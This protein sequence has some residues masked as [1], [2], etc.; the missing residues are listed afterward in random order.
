MIGDASAR[1][2]PGILIG[3]KS[4]PNSFLSKTSNYRPKD[5]GRLIGG[6]NNSKTIMIYSSQ[7]E[8]EKNTQVIPTPKQEQSATGI[9]QHQRVMNTPSFFV[10]DSSAALNQPGNIYTNPVPN[11]DKSNSEMWSSLLKNNT[12]NQNGVKNVFFT[13]SNLDEANKDKR[14]EGK[15]F[16]NESM[17][18]QSENNQNNAASQI[19]NFKNLTRESADPNNIVNNNHTTNRE[20]EQKVTRTGINVPESGQKFVEQNE[21]MN[22]YETP[23]KEAQKSKRDY[24][25]SNMENTEVKNG[26]VDKFPTEP[27]KKEIEDFDQDNMNVNDREVNNLKAVDPSFLA[28][29]KN[30]SFGADIDDIDQNKNEDMKLPDD[31]IEPDSYNSPN[32]NSPLEGSPIISKK[33]PLEDKITTNHEKTSDVA[34]KLSEIRSKMQKVN[35]QPIVN[36]AEQIPESRIEFNPNDRKLNEAVNTQPSENDKEIIKNT[37]EVVGQNTKTDYF[38]SSL[39]VEVKEEIKNIQERNND[40]GPSTPKNGQVTNNQ[41]DLNSSNKKLRSEK[42]TVTFTIQ[43]QSAQNQPNDK[44]L[45]QF[46]SKPAPANDTTIEGNKV[47]NFTS[48]GNNKDYFLKDINTKVKVEPENL[49]KPKGQNPYLIDTQPKKP[50]PPV[51]IKQQQNPTINEDINVNRYLIPL[52][53]SRIANDPL[54]RYLLDKSRHFA[55]HIENAKLYTSKTAKT[56]SRRMESIVLEYKEDR[57]MFE[58]AY[59]ASKVVQDFQ[60]IKQIFLSIEKDYEKTIQNKSEVL[61]TSSNFDANMNFRAGF[62]EEYNNR[63]LRWEQGFSKCQKIIDTRGKR[64]EQNS[65]ESFAGKSFH[66]VS[67]KNQILTI[68]NQKTFSIAPLTEK[69]VNWSAFKADNNTNE[70]IHKNLTM[71][72]RKESTPE[73]SK[74]GHSPKF[75]N[76]NGDLTR[77]RYHEISIQDTRLDTESLPLVLYKQSITRIEND[78]Q[79]IYRLEAAIEERN[80]RELIETSE[81]ASKIV[82]RY[83]L[84]YSMNHTFHQLYSRLT[85]SHNN[86]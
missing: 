62:L 82:E 81:H 8:Q 1:I 7:E 38:H 49:E 9:T 6:N 27:P 23:K 36:N 59:K 65:I 68:K 18:N 35:P 54:Y 63:L 20:Q 79:D 44:N 37:R 43:D 19:V 72:Y 13:S 84:Q 70:R 26:Q 34:F 4:E 14:L 40:N 80:R 78:L 83:K 66:N 53:D 60:N 51:N 45:T 42:K 31:G 11:S 73:K 32:N 75:T 29:T 41:I 86:T 16:K 57:L 17:I 12:E 56:I 58:G 39:K 69:K 3:E 71:N 85:V 52:N 48:S 28:L 74:T 55:K 5:T 64:K 10:K 46:D 22:L 77:K 30:I 2:S 24:Q 15:F 50:V 61:K 33:E 25:T 21:E 47:L 76:R 67:F